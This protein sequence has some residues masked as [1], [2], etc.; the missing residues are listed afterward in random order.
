M[1]AWNGQWAEDEFLRARTEVLALWPTGSDVDLEDGIAFQRSLPER[2]RENLALA[3][4]KAEDRVLLQPRAGVALLDEHIALMRALQDDGGADI[5]PTTIDSYTR[6]LKYAD[7]TKAIAESER[8]GTSQLNGLPAV[9]YGT[10]ACRRIVEAV[11]RPVCI[12]TA[13][14]DV[15]LTAEVLLAAGFTGQTHG[16]MADM[17]YSKDTPVEQ[18]I[19]LWQ[20]V[21]RLSAYYTEHGAPIVRE[22]Y[23]PSSSVTPPSMQHALTILDALL[24]LEQGVRHVNVGYGQY[25]C[26]LQDVAALV[27]LSR[28]MEHFAERLGWGGVQITCSLHQW[29]GG[30]PEDEARAFGIICLGAAVAA[31]GG[32]Q[33]I[34]VKTPHE[35]WGVPTT[36]ANVQ[37]L[38][39]TSQALSMLKH[40]RL[41]MAG[42]LATEVTMIERETRALIERTLELGDGGLW[43]GISRAFEVGVLDQ[44]FS[45]NRHNANRVMAAR[46]RQGAARYLDCGNLPF[47]AEIR[48]YHREKIAERARAEGRPVSYD[49]VIDDV[50]A[51][52]EARTV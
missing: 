7:A 21:N 16:P 49:L 10:A 17:G 32:A 3:S 19:A 22:H 30:F 31:L 34:H 42:E 20:Y 41:P 24:S 27:A 45:P 18:L 33:M 4:A 25:G 35:A 46:D 50:Y 40:Q 28:L 43:Q 1:A 13:A 47:D 12:R 15:R 51:L 38:K 23:V 39:A 52:S 5:L 11:E 6:G 36:E 8:T 37:G 44:P 26:L 9:S 14:P 29:M 2:K 48:E